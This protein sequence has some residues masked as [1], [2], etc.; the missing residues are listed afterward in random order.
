MF[1]CKLFTCHK[2]IKRRAQQILAFS[3]NKSQRDALFLEIYFDKVLYMF[4]A[5]LL[6]I[7]SSLNT[8]YTARGIC[9][10]SSVGY[11]LARSLAEANRTSMTNSYCCVY[12]VE[13][14][15]DGQQICPKHAEYF[16]KI[17]LRNSTSHWLLL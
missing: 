3:Y 4:R 16:I 13:T 15:D 12:S 11:L 7:I 6:S 2:G 17:N 14:P 8:V 1:C 5:D 10:A 9:H